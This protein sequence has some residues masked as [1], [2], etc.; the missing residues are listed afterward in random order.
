M[1]FLVR[2]AIDVT[3]EK[4]QRK[5]ILCQDR[6][7]WWGFLNTLDLSAPARPGPKSYVSGRR[8]NLPYLAGR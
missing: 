1:F 2:S 6:G 4:S 8:A 3:D 5:A 7:L